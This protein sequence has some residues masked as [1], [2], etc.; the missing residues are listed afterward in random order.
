VLA[1]AIESPPSWLGSA[2]AILAAATLASWAALGLS[3]WRRRDLTRDQR[4][5]W[6][7]FA[8][9]LGVAAVLVYFVHM[10]VGR[11]RGVAARATG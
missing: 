3:L 2:V 8:I 11:A 10:L 6:I 9:V 4:A 1:D 7:L 5:N